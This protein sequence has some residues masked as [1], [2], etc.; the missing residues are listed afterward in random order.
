MLSSSFDP[1]PRFDLV[2]RARIPG[3][4]GI[5]HVAATKRGLLQIA[6]PGCETREFESLVRQRLRRPARG[7]SG[8]D[9]EALL[10]LVEDLL[11]SWS[12]RAVE[13]CYE[14]PLPLD[15]RGTEFQCRGLVGAEQAAAGARGLLWRACAGRWQLWGC[16]SDWGCDAGEP[17]PPFRALSPCPGAR[18]ARWLS[19]GHCGQA[20][21]TEARGARAERAPHSS[22]G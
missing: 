14:D 9:P 19:G 4:A 17:S 5:Y 7:K 16:A 8:A 22:S 15:M 11:A 2:L 10:L 1:S 3:P 21:A 18:W 12:R 20:R 13:R 6:L